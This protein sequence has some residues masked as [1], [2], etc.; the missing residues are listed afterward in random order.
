MAAQGQRPYNVASPADWPR[1]TRDLE[2]TRF[3]PL[4]QIDTDNVA[5][6]AHELAEMAGF[7]VVRSYVGESAPAA[8]CP[9]PRSRSC[10]STASWKPCSTL[11]L[12]ALRG[13]YNPFPASPHHEGWRERNPAFRLPA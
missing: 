8:K 11:P 10:G 5:A 6:K 3:S 1:Y 13:S 2:G 12:K 4:D 7:T 9:A